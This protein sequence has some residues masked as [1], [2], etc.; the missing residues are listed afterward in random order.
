VNPESETKPKTESA[1][2]GAQVQ[3]SAEVERALGEGRPVVALESTIL[4][5]GLPFP[6]NLETQRAAE[7]AVRREGAVP[8]LVSIVDGVPRA[9]F[10][11]AEVESLAL[12][13]R[14]VRKATT[15]DLGLLAARRESGA[16]TVAA[17]M[18][19]ASAA[20]IRVFATGGI[21]GVHRG[22]SET[23]DVSAD[24]LELSR[25]RVAVVASGAKAVLD[26]PKTLEA[27]ESLGVPVLGFGTSEFP[28][29]WIRGSGLPLEVCCDDALEVARVVLAH[30]SWPRAGGVLVANP[31]PW[32]AALAKRDVE[33]AIERCLAAARETGIAGKAVTPWL[34]ARLA[35][36]TGGRTL[37][38]NRALVV[39][40]AVVAAR[41][42]VALDPGGTRG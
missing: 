1:R 36:E 13:G 28:A 5:H 15:R 33:E 35:E 3:L 10:S 21:G 20:G 17:T 32:E 42:A 26:L 16:T 4:C 8:A 41:I 12:A 14:S 22:A 27:L 40:N 7:E 23:F 24:L 34:L 25:T 39:S 29:F 37:A 6:T 11:P 9:G 38:A 2:G 30:W 19:I 31:V 18:A